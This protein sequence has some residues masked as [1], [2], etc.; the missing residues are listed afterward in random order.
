[1]PVDD[2]DD[3]SIPHPSDRAPLPA[4]PVL[5]DTRDDRVA[6]AQRLIEGIVARPTDALAGVQVD[7][8]GVHF[9]LD[10]PSLERGRSVAHEA[11]DALRAAGF[12]SWTTYAPIP[13]PLDAG[14]R[15]LIIAHLGSDLPD[16]VPHG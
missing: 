6:L 10:V 16:E 3:M 2:E 4:R 11:A 13:L 5:P 14:F 8:D 12:R 1:M 15:V 9:A 7:D